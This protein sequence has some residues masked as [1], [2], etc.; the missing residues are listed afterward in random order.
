MLKSTVLFYVVLCLTCAFTSVSSLKLS[1]TEVDTAFETFKKT[2][3]KSYQTP[4]I[5]EY[6]KKVFINNLG[7]IEEINDNA[8]TFVAGITKFTD[9]TQSEIS[10]NLLTYREEEETNIPGGIV[11]TSLIQS[12]KLKNRTRQASCTLITPSILS[13]VVDYRTT[14][15]LSPIRDQGWCGCCWAYGTIFQ[16]EYYYRKKTGTQIDLSV[17]ELVDCN[18]GNFAC[19]G[20]TLSKSMSFQQ[21]WNATPADSYPYIDGKGTCKFASAAAVTPA[22]A[23]L[24]NTPTTLLG[25][26]TDAIVN[27]LKTNGPLLTTVDSTYLPFYVSGIFDPAAFQYDCLTANHAV[28][29]VGAGIDPITNKVYYIIRNSW[30]LTWGENGYFRIFACVCKIGAR[31]MYAT[32]K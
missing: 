19:D 10:K 30:G 14:G 29:I 12:K 7:V 31:S 13:T 16:L 20:G 6:R 15:I 18:T 25:A 26:T 4:E 21:T 2:Y 32:M 3:N 8:E 1:K 5:E 17:Q 23:T 28:N 9:N 11:I 27:A 22:V 24:L